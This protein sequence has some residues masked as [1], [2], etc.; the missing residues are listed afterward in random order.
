MGSRPTAASGAR[1]ASWAQDA[2]FFATDVTDGGGGVGAAAGAGDCPA[3][4][5]GQ[6]S[7]SRRPQLRRPPTT[8][9]RRAADTVA[10]TG[11]VWRV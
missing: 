7:R 11:G 10:D 9:C 4:T 3:L 6:R 5:A 2:R 1:G 8:P